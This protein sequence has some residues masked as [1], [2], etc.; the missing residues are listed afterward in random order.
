M[1]LTQYR[2]FLT[3]FQRLYALYIFS[4]KFRCLFIYIWFFIMSL[5]FFLYFYPTFNMHVKNFFSV[6]LH[7]K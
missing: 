6:E 7:A 4:I 3:L 2:R 5:C 1:R